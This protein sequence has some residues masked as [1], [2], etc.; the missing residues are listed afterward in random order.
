MPKTVYFIRHA[1]SAWNVPDNLPDI[2]RPLAERGW[3]DSAKMGDYL[4]K[5][6]ISL[7]GI[8]SSPAV[9][10]Y[11]TAR[12][13]AEALA[14]APENIL[15]RASIY[16]ASAQVL[17]SVLQ[18]APKAW[19]SLA[20]FGHNPEFTQLAALYAPFALEN[21]PTS[22]VFALRWPVQNWSEIRS[23][24]VPDWLFWAYPKGI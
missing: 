21:I 5:Q 16:E 7:D 22:G 14:L 3:Q 8:L 10:A 19:Q 17:L 23:E 2:D 9:R 4:A 6:G 18:T 11:S 13:I 15:I 1:K 20:L 24:I 12:R